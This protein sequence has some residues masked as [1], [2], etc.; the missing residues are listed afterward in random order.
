MH[1]DAETLGAQ[2][3]SAGQSLRT[4]ECDGGSS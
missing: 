2:G 1:A 3:Q 4:T